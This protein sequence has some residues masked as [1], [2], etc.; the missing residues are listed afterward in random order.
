MLACDGKRFPWPFFYS[1]NHMPVTIREVAD[2]AGVSIATVSRVLNHKAHPVG[3]A[4]RRRILSLAEEM[5]YRPNQAARSLRTERSSTIG[6]VTD[7]IDSPH[8]TAMIRGIQDR[9]KQNGYI[10]VVISAEWDPQIE[11]EAIRDLASRSIDGIIFAETWHRSAIEILALSDKP[12]V[13]VH[14]QFA[15]EHPHSVS[16]DEVYGARLATGHLIRLEHRRIGYINGPVEYYASADRLSGYRMELEENGIAFDDALVRDGDWQVKS[17]YDAALELLDAAPRPTAIFAGND[18]M[19]AG[20]MYAI[21]DTGLRVPQ[22]IAVVGYDNRE[23]ARIFRPAMTTVTLPLNAMGQASAQML[24]DLLQGE[25]DAQA[26]V[27]IRGELIIRESCGAP[28]DQRAPSI[29]P[30]L[31]QRMQPITKE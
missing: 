20:A 1:N 27:K 12:F 22:D 9:A 11:R 2:A 25:R 21:T 6:I 19:A 29:L 31:R 16:P 17:G 10:C 30:R 24:L 4:T 13:F 18:L 3:D 26:E 23:I 7:N 8:T 28:A 5:G 14:R 15:A